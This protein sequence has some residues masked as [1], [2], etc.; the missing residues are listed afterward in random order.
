M[1]ENY[2]DVT[3]GDVATTLAQLM[4][5][6]ADEHELLLKHG[7]EET[8]AVEFG[9]V[10]RVRVDGN[11]ARFVITME[12]GRRYGVIVDELGE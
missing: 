2:I 1:A 9:D 6:M 3:A 7:T 10:S 11:V 5:D 4:I 8:L 12:D